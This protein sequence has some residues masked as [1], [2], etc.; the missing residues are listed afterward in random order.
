MAI[1]AGYL[2]TPEGEAAV[3]RAGEEA[4]LRH[5]PLVVVDLSSDRVLVDERSL[6][7]D[8]EAVRQQ[9]VDADLEFHLASPTALDPDDAIVRTAQRRGA[10]LIVIGLRHR[11]AVGTLLFGS[12]AQKVVLH[13]DCPVLVVKGPSNGRGEPDHPHSRD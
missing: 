3:H 2:A 13:A 1:I 11:S 6:P 10:D 12:Y 7:A 5:R 9:V 4:I 8:V